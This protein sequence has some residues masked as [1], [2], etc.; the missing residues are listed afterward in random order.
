MSLRISLQRF[1]AEHSR[2]ACSREFFFFFFFKSIL[3]SQRL[4]ILK[5]RVAIKNDLEKKTERDKVGFLQN[6]DRRPGSSCLL[7]GGKN[8]EAMTQVENSC[9]AG[10]ANDNTFPAES[11]LGWFVGCVPPGLCFPFCDRGFFVRF[12]LPHIAFF[13]FALVCPFLL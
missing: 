3:C 1:S 2:S 6:F 11:P 12:L 7:R 4:E 8:E 5:N 9:A 10:I 13:D